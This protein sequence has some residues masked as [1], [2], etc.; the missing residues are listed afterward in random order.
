MDEICFTPSPSHSPSPFATLLEFGDMRIREY[1]LDND[2]LIEGRNANI[3]MIE[4]SILSS[5]V[6]GSSRSYLTSQPSSSKSIFDVF[7]KSASETP[8]EAEEEEEISINLPSK[9]APFIFSSPEEATEN[10]EQEYETAESLEESDTTES[11]SDGEDDN[12]EFEL[13]SDDDGEEDEHFVG[14]FPSNIPHLLE[15]PMNDIYTPIWRNFKN[16]IEESTT[17]N[18]KSPT[19]NE[20]NSKTYDM[21]EL[22]LNIETLFKAN[23]FKQLSV[24]DELSKLLTGNC[25]IIGAETKIP[26]IEESIKEELPAVYNKISDHLIPCSQKDQNKLYLVELWWA[27]LED[28]MPEC[29]SELLKRFKAFAVEKMR[30]KSIIDAFENLAGQSS[31]RAIELRQ[32]G[33][34]IYDLQTLEDNELPANY[35]PDTGP[36][37][38]RRQTMGK[39]SGDEFGAESEESPVQ[40]S[41][42]RRNSISESPTPVK[43]LRAD[44]N[45]KEYEIPQL[46]HTISL[47]RRISTLSHRSSM[48][49]PIISPSIGSKASVPQTPNKDTSSL[50]SSPLAFM[51]KKRQREEANPNLKRKNTMKFKNASI[52]FKYPH[53]GEKEIPNEEEEENPAV[54]QG[55]GCDSDSIL[56]GLKIK[57]PLIHS[58][59]GQRLSTLKK[60]LERISQRR[61]TASD[62]DSEVEPIRKKVVEKKKKPPKIQYIDKR[63]LPEHPTTSEEEDEEEEE[64]GISGDDLEEY[65]EFESQENSSE[66]DIFD[67]D[68]VF[69]HNGVEFEGPILKK[70]IKAGVLEVE[71]NGAITDA[72]EDEHLFGAK[73]QSFSQITEMDDI[74]K[75]IA[76]IQNQLTHTVRQAQQQSKIIFDNL[77]FESERRQCLK[78]IIQVETTLCDNLEGPVSDTN[79][80]TLAESFKQLSMIYD[81]HGIVIDKLEDFDIEHIAIR[82]L[83]LNE[84]FY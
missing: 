44:S 49:P 46:S 5:P 70:L 12:E 4:Q 80:E 73:K 8:S 17:K 63:L 52:C 45:S 50:F 69:V 41:R 39:E 32:L 1:P 62:D 40:L 47:S 26:E 7:E 31:D 22:Q 18:L 23:L 77:A 83:N 16:I 42:K 35:E 9:N 84:R 68:Q 3:S 15:E 19:E 36:I 28:L 76:L 71:E 79:P 67:H 66:E 58:H 20:L 30:P 27:W 55:D 59:S 43:R 61:G 60:K 29:S 11:E 57:F 24:I 25:A 38:Y 10:S 54:W 53:T 34:K 64:K 48:S 56:S 33:T 51:E 72:T 37:Y 14:Y 75:E 81:S 13:G 21:S 78:Q 74:S 6:A 65:S 82:A 2:S